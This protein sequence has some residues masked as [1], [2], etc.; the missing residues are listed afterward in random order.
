[1]S[2]IRPRRAQ[3]KLPE[4]GV[5]GAN[6]RRERAAAAM[7]QERLA[8]LADLNVRTLQKIEAGQVNILITTVLRLQQALRCR[9]SR[10][11]PPDGP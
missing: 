5:F 8:E 1:M 6:L 11:L 10:L 7:T 9:W 2:A 3:P 4:L